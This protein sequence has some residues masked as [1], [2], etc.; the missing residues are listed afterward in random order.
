MLLRKEL[1]LFCF[2]LLSAFL[3]ISASI[4]HQVTST[5]L[6][7]A[8]YDAVERRCG[9]EWG[10]APRV[11]KEGSKKF[12]SQ[13]PVQKLARQK[14]FFPDEGLVEEVSKQMCITGEFR[15]IPSH[16]LLS[17][18]PV[19]DTGENG[20]ESYM[21]ENTPLTQSSTESY[22]YDKPYQSTKVAF[23]SPF[24]IGAFCVGAVIGSLVTHYY[25]LLKISPG[26]SKTLRRPEL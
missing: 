22:S 25:L 11:L 1:A 23:G 21:N 15:D 20:L 19:K 13:I 2:A 6:K 17:Q 14:E 7:L 24:V 16:S 26:S 5:L 10:D 9:S 18:V 8:L 12:L 4:E 3:N